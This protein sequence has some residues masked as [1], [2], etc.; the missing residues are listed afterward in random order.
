VIR[1]SISESDM[2]SI[3][4]ALDD[5]LFDDRSKR[6]L[7][8]IRMHAA[9]VP[10]GTI[11]S[12]LNISDD[13]VTNYCKLFA[14]GGISALLE[15]R[16]FIPSSKVEAFFEQI[17]A[18]LIENP[19]FSAKQ[20]AARIRE[21]TGFG[22]SETQTRRI[23]KRLGLGYRQAAAVPGGANPQM[24]LDFLR[25]ELLPRLDEARKG[26]RRVFFVDA[27]HFVLGAFLGMV[28]CLQR[29]FVKSGS[30]RQRYSVLGAVETRN[31]DFVSV[32]TAGSVNSET[33]CALL[34]TIHQRYPDEPITLV[35]DNARYQRNAA[36]LARANQLRLEL[37]FLPAYSPNLNLIE[38]VWR[39]VRNQ[40]LR[41]RF[42]PDF[43][44]FRN[45]IDDFLDSLN[46]GN[47][48]YLKTLIT[49]NFQ[50]FSFPKS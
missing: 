23:M 9:N 44:S 15:N 6:K 21:I 33:L 30:G 2:E 13:T 28:W 27:A 35:L 1:L 22:L 29:L 39:L 19:V 34:E 18:S 4:E 8:A 49:E 42:F 17:K 26:K 7:L 12:T 50:T 11:A 24:Q 14:A 41:N 32:R 36:V 46:K 43:A 16:Y 3:A 37:L 5:P 38:R 47:R 48:H 31:H 45:S 10:H 25:D 40:A 20:G